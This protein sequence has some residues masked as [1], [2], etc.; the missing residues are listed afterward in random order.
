MPKKKKC[1]LCEQ[2]IEHVDYKRIDLLNNFISDKYKILPRRNTKNC[3]KHQR[4]VSKAVKRARVAG[5]I[6]FIPAV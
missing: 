4:K 1:I 3:S 6:P 5:F 2:K